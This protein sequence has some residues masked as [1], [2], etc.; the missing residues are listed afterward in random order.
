MPPPTETPAPDPMLPLAKL[1]AKI[2]L[3]RGDG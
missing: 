1:A 3:A 2:D